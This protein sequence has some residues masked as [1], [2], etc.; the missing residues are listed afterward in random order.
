MTVRSKYDT[1]RKISTYK[2]RK[3][4]EQFS[5]EKM[6]VL[7]YK[8]IVKSHLELYTPLTKH[9][10]ERFIYAGTGR[11]R[12][13]CWRTEKLSYKGETQH[14]AVSYRDTQFRYQK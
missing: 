12:G 14:K 5:R 2:L 13:P 1:A 8:A 11:K 3:F 4:Q 6:E 7:V 10:L 9:F